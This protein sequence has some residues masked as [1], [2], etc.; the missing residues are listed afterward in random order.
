LDRGDPHRAAGVTAVLAALMALGVA[1]VSVVV[2]VLAF[3]YAVRWVGKG[4]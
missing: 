4:R 2:A 3:V 1:L